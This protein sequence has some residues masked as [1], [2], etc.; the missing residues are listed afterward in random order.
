MGTDKA[1]VLVDG[2]PMLRR[3]AVAL[4]RAGACDVACVGSAADAGTHARRR[5][6]LAGLQVT[7]VDDDHPGEG[8]LGGILTALRAAPEDVEVVLVVACDLVAPSPAALEATV[9]GLGDGDVA[10]PQGREWLHA[11]W[12]R[13]ALPELAERFSAGERSVHRAVAGLHVVAVDVAPLAC[14]DADV[15]DD[16]PSP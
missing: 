5:G 4:R 12:H 15:P 10:V 1:L 11:A 16:L 13:R 8:P 9:A 14:R 3:V 6:A 7:A 2:E